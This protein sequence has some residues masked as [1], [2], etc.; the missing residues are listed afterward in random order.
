MLARGFYQLTARN[1]RIKGRT[2]D[3][4]SYAPLRAAP[5]ATHARVARAWAL[6]I[7]PKNWGRRGQDGGRARAAAAVGDDDLSGGRLFLLIKKP[8]LLS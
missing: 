4:T 6:Y 5:R 2:S 8:F 7:K 1:A 3:R